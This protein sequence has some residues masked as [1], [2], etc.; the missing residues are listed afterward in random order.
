MKDKQKEE[1]KKAYNLLIEIPKFNSADYYI[2]PISVWNEIIKK[3]QYFEATLKETKIS[4]DRWKEKYY[5]L[6]NSD[7]GRKRKCGGEDKMKGGN[8]T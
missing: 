6:Q 2:L 3:I 1:I 8:K 5:T 4:R 7:K